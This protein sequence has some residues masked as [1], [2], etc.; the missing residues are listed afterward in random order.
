MPRGSE[1]NG[2]RFVRPRSE[3]VDRQFVGETRSVAAYVA[4]GSALRFGFGVSFRRENLNG[5]LWGGN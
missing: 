2:A 4:T 3:V 1:N 5:I